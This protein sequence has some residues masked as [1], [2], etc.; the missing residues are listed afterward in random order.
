MET[1]EEN[2]P[3][4]NLSYSVDYIGWIRAAPCMAT[5][6][7]LNERRW[8]LIGPDSAR[9]LWSGRRNSVF[10][11][12]F[13]QS[14]AHHAICNQSSN[15]QSITEKILIFFFFLFYFSQINLPKI[16][17]CWR[18]LAGASPLLKATPI[19][20]ATRNSRPLLWWSCW[21]CRWCWFMDSHEPVSRAT[22]QLGVC[23]TR[24][25]R[26]VSNINRLPSHR[27][28]FHWFVCQCNVTM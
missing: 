8:K 17:P 23:F 24:R 9:H 10:G 16:R 1:E 14:T 2:Q 3:A 19:G 11:E 25:R 26:P 13:C 28:L 7:Q 6:V 20:T 15:L 21:C 12:I 27:L 5:F 22:C 4:R 18:H